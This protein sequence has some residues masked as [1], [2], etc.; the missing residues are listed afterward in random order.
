MGTCFTKQK[1]WKEALKWFNK[2]VT[3]NPKNSKAYHKRGNC[4]K[5]LGKFVAAEVDYKQANSIDPSLNLKSE[6]R[7]LQ[8]K[9]R[10]EKKKDYYKI[11]GVDKNATDKEIK[12]AFRKCTLKYHPDKQGGKTDEEK[13]EAENKFKECN[14]A[15]NVL[16]DPK[17]RQM[18][19]QGI[20]NPDG[21]GGMGGGAHF[22]MSDLFGGMG[23][24]GMPDIFQMFGGMG[25]GGRSRGGRSSGGNPFGGSQGFS[26]RFG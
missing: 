4:N 11:L 10:E 26:F 23:G 14:E 6:I 3:A 24:G 16:S 20:Y 18:V 19:D 9:A 22:N 17:K 8:K 1:K 15:Y 7:N 21:Q 25:G 2:S 13:T 12:K 5:E